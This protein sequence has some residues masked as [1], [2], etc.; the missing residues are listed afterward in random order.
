[1]GQAGGQEAGSTVGAWSGFAVGRQCGR[2]HPSFTPPPVVLLPVWLQ[3]QARCRAGSN[4]ASGPPM[5]PGS[6]TGHNMCVDLVYCRSAIRQPYEHH[7][8]RIM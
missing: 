8:S 6:C 5:P 1:M 4:T 7:P 3:V 2:L